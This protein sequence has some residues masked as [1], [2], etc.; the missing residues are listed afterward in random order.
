MLDNAKDEIARLKREVERL[1]I[2][3]AIIEQAIAGAAADIEEVLGLTVQQARVVSVLLSGRP[4][5]DEQLRDLCWPGKDLSRSIVSTTIS[6]IR[7]AVKWLV[8][9]KEFRGGPYM[10]KA[11]S[12]DRVKSMIAAMR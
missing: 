11:A 8:I 9:C 2:R 12:I 5:H 3:C 1:T 6:D 4:Y 7:Q 10:M